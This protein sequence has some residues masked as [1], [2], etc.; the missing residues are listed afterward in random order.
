MTQDTRHTP[1]T[2]VLATTAE[3]V[4]E[5]PL[6]A[7]LGQALEK[8]GGHCTILGRK[9]VIGQLTGATGI[10][11]VVPSGPAAD[12]TGSGADRGLTR[13]LTRLIHHLPDL[14]DTPPILCV[15]TRTHRTASSDAAPSAADRQLIDLL[16][17]VRARY[18][19][20]PTTHITLD[21]ATAV[22]DVATTLLADAVTEQPITTR[23]GQRRTARPQQRSTEP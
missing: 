5:D 20:L 4:G 17:T 2:W 21:D 13:W 9:A 22:Q 14:S 11:A 19:R 3:S 1:G 6:P 15:V 10:I 8:R 7:Q 23:H 18:P 12:R 16:H